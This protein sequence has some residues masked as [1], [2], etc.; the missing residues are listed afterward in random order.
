[1]PLVAAAELPPLAACEVCKV[2]EAD[3]AQP[4]LDE[5]IDVVVVVVL[6]SV[7]GV[8]AAA[9]LGPPVDEAAAATVLSVPVMP[10]DTVVGGEGLPH[11]ALPLVI[12]LLPHPLLP[13]STFSMLSAD[14]IGTVFSAP[15]QTEEE[16]EALSSLPVLVA[17]GLVPVTAD[18]PRIVELDITELLDELS[19]ACEAAVSPVVEV[20]VCNAVDVDP[21][22]GL[23]VPIEG[24][25]SLS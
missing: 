11:T 12:V 20:V 13:E 23:S 1:M 24:Q 5:D 15:P 17:S 8:V 3:V 19:A 4:R 7:V 14:W 6:E 10:V 22:L 16:D 9:P 18:K 25:A 2:G 21:L